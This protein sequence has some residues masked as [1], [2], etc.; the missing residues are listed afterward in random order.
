[1]PEASAHE[2]QAL[3][4]QKAIDHLLTSD[5]GHPEWVT[6]VAFY[7]A[8]HLVEA[9]FCCD[10]KSPKKHT[11]EH[12]VRNGM[13]RGTKS[14]SKIWKHYAPLYRLSLLARY[15]HHT[16]GGGGHQS[17]ADY[18]SVDDVKDK[19]LGHR[20][21]QIEKACKNRMQKRQLAK[22]SKSAKKRK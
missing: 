4:N 9:V 2:Q 13:L 10:P 5:E 19:V 14:F 21:K 8:L 11:C 20:L 18:M 22:K 7:K 6:T 15:L 1:M 16:N 12:S 17:F 3:R